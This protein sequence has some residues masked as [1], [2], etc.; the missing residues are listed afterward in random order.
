MLGWL[1]SWIGWMDGWMDGWLDKWIDLSIHS[2]YPLCVKFFHMS[3]WSSK[4]SF[5]ISLVHGKSPKYFP[6]KTGTRFT[7]VL[8]ASLLYL[9]RCKDN[10]GNWKVGDLNSHIT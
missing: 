5:F 10:A 1:V 2:F 6:D 4:G 3:G 8:S 7:N 9:E